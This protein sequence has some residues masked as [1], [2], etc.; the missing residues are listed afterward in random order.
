MILEVNNIV[1]ND[2]KLTFRLNL[3]DGNKTVERKFYFNFP[4]SISF[5][6]INEILLIPST[7]ALYIA[8]YYHNPT[9]V[10][11][12]KLLEH[13][14]KLRMLSNHIAVS[15]CA[16]VDEDVF[17]PNIRFMKSPDKQ[18][19]IN[20]DMIEVRTD[21]NALTSASGGKESLLNKVILEQMGL[22][23]LLYQVAFSTFAYNKGMKHYTKKIYN[24]PIFV[25]RTNVNVLKDFYPIKEERLENFEGVP[26]MFYREG[27]VG[28]H[29]IWGIIL[30]KHFDIPN[31][32]GAHEYSD[33]YTYQGHDYFPGLSEDKVWFDYL[34]YVSGVNY[35]SLLQSIQRYTELQLIDKVYYDECKDFSSCITL[36]NR[37]C[38]QCDKCL[39]TYLMWKCLDIDPKRY[40]FD[41]Q[42]LF[43]KH[44]A[45]KKNYHEFKDSTFMMT[46]EGLNLVKD[47]VMGRL[48]ASNTPDSALVPLYK[49]FNK[50]PVSNPSDIKSK[51]EIKVEMLKNLPLIYRNKM[52]AIIDEWDLK[53]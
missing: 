41:Q 36:I 26:Y 22:S 44:E 40:G 37:W 17:E 25:G 52:K 28:I 11:P 35:F 6:A 31:V 16:L 2:Q 3:E 21:Y 8:S 18:L 7:I 32:F 45:F 1:V 29:S 14:D 48:D 46:D 10:M 27:I 13:K 9:L 19:S 47:R 53:Y 30:A 4:F 12:E 39:T 33:S 20:M 34:S 43:K 24:Q 50:I 38:H 51:T 5:N 15:N 23:P 49:L 42:A